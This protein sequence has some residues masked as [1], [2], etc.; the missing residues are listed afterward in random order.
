MISILKE[1]FKSLES[2]K[3]VKLEMFEEG[4]T[5]WVFRDESEYGVY[6]IFDNNNDVYEKFSSMKVK[7]ALTTYNGN[8]LKILML[9]SN[10]F[11]YSNEFATI[12][13]DFIKLGDNNVNRHS[14][15]KNPFVWIDKW[16]ELVGNT[17]RNLTVYDV[18][19]ELTALLYLQTNGH[20]PIWYAVDSGTH[21]IETDSASYEVKS[22]INKKD[23]HITISSPHQ[24][25][26]TNNKKLFLI[27][28]RFEK[29][30]HGQSIENLIEQLEQAGIDKNMI[31]EHLFDLGYHKGRK[32]RKVT[33]K[34]LDM[35]LYEVNDKF[36]VLT[37]NQF[38]NNQLPK[39]IIHYSYTVDL[40]NLVYKKIE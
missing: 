34:V 5:T 26:T 2:G 33:Y 38:I 14:L 30:E 18:L 31:N 15:I 16:K 3:R 19:G 36:P 20:N 27:F 13:F 12:A 1:L 4:Q 39:G 23:L 8:T 40:S 29:S 11:T 37:S 7:S 22:T 25:V 6:F 21:D 24:L 10:N 17:K 9:T 35:Y 32:E 28:C